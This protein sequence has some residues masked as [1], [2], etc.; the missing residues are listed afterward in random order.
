MSPDKLRIK[1]IQSLAETTGL[2]V[3][4]VL[5]V[6][7]ALSWEVTDAEVDA[8]WE[9]IDNRYGPISITHEDVRI[10]LQAAL[11]TRRKNNLRL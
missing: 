5:Y 3:S 2:T 6:F 1:Q 8:A 11:D 7:N 4:E 9:A 10:G